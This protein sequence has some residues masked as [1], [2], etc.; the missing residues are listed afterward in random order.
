MVGKEGAQGGALWVADQVQFLDL[1]DGYKDTNH[2]IIHRA[3]HLFFVF[4]VSVFKKVVVVSISER[5]V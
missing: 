5:L 2:I 4:S 1:S 3:I